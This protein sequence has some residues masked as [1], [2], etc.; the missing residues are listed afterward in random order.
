MKKSP[1][2]RGGHIERISIP[3]DDAYQWIVTL[4]EQGFSEEEVESVM[5]YLNEEFLN[6]KLGEII[7]ERLNRMNETTRERTGEEMT[8]EKREVM[9]KIITAQIRRL[10]PEDIM[11]GSESNLAW[12]EKVAEKAKELIPAIDPNLRVRVVFMDEVDKDQKV[13]KTIKV[14]FADSVKGFVWATSVPREFDLER[15]LEPLIR[16]S[17][18]AVERAAGEAR[19]EAK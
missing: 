4:R 3:S 1:E 12:Y 13:R 15:H 10:G 16:Q 5:L 8:R 17:Y 18:Q 14:E 9:R 7:E 6:Q 11:G 19:P 2:P